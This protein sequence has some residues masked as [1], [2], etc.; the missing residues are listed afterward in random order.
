MQSYKIFSKIE[1][2]FVNI[3]RVSIKDRDRGAYKRKKQHLEKKVLVI[4][5]GL[6]FIYIL[7][8]TKEKCNPS[9]LIFLPLT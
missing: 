2:F 7:P 3:F 4:M 1:H 8:T 6:S 9:A 5:T